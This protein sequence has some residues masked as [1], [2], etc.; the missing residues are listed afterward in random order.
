M[1]AIGS[2]KAMLVQVT[3]QNNLSTVRHTGGVLLQFSTSK[4]RGSQNVSNIYI[5]HVNIQ[6]GDY[7]DFKYYTWEPNLPGSENM[8]TEFNNKW[9][10]EYTITV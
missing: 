5:R 6:W 7:P 8:I 10:E 2:L 9:E 3:F 1:E 4:K